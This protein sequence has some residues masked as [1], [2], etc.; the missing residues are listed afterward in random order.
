[1]KSSPPK[2]IAKRHENI[3]PEKV[4]LKKMHTADTWRK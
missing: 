1:M 3:M 4:V 2:M